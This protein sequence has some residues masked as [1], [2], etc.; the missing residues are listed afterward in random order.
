MLSPW[1]DS[2]CDP[3]KVSF[4]TIPQFPGVDILGGRTRYEEDEEPTSEA[5][6]L[7]VDYTYGKH[8]R[9]VI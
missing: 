2:P 1:F 8:T 5:Q 6:F 4:S 3:V 9:S 7:L